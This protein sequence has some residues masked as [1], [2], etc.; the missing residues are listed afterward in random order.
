MAA[1][2]ADLAGRT[3][4]VRIGE[5]L[6]GRCSLPD[7]RLNVNTLYLGRDPPKQQLSRGQLEASELRVTTASFGGRGSATR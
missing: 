5:D 6:G 7:R 1:V 4:T 3:K 2:A